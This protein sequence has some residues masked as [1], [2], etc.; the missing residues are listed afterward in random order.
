MTGGQGGHRGRW[1]TRTTT[2]EGRHVGR[3]RFGPERLAFR[4]MT[5][6]RRGRLAG[7]SDGPSEGEELHEVA[8][9]GPVLIEEILSGE[10]DAPSEFLQ[11]HDEWVVV[12]SGSATLEVRATGEM[13]DTLFDLGENDWV[14]I[15]AGTRH[16]VLHNEPGTRWLAV[17]LH[18]R[19]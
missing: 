12:L 13:G 1:R 8:R 9:L 19:G 7:P 14:V 3:A 4:P 10:R 5:A 11:D 18:R 16:R 15:P 17:H 2:G 6:I